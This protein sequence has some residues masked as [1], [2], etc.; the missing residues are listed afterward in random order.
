MVGV[1]FTSQGLD[2]GAPYRRESGSFDPRAA[3][4]F[5][6][7]GQDE[8][9]GDF[10]SLVLEHGAGGFEL[11]RLDPALGSP[12]HALLL[13]SSSGYSD[14]FQHVIEE[15]LASNPNEGGSRNPLVRADMV[16]FEY[17]NG[18]AVFSVGSISWCGSLSYEAYENNVSQITG[19]VL[20]RFISGDR[21][22]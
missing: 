7:V 8:P 11:D 14:Y 12:P 6:G 3:F 5:E 10:E 15:V 16:Y 1:G 21:L 9:I 2:R 19:N 17:P 22:S 13:A 4:I 18:G 20:R